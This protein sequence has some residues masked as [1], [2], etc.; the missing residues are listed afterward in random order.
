MRRKATVGCQKML[1]Q[2]CAL[3]LNIHGCL[4]S[5]PRMCLPGTVA[6]WHL[7]KERAAVTT[8]AVGSMLKVDAGRVR[9]F[10]ALLF[11]QPI[12]GGRS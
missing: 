8:R 1:R 3:K 6:S 2:Q 12:E 11:M 7:A 10:Y 4:Y 5:Q 9:P